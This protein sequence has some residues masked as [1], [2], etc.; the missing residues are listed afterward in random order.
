MVALQFL[1][2]PASCLHYY[3][4]KLEKSLTFDL[5]QDKWHETLKETLKPLYNVFASIRVLYFE[6]R[7][8]PINLLVDVSNLLH[9]FQLEKKNKLPV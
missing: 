5:I 9:F 7:V 8:Q 2:S 6:S 1:Y 4:T 3:L